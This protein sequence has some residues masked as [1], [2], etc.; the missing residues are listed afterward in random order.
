MTIDTITGSW[1]P[2]GYSV[3][4]GA[5][6]ALN[7]LLVACC[8]EIPE[9]YLEVLPSVVFTGSQ[10]L[11]KDYPVFPCPMKEQEATAAAR[12]LEGMAVAAIAAFRYPRRQS[13]SFILV[14]IS[15]VACFL[16][17]A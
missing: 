4:G 15:K 12:A 14:D 3:K 13:E 10:E 11:E 16:M 7:S 1:A 9:A 5:L 2:C 6:K 8:N 17:S